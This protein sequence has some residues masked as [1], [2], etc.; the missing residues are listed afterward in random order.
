MGMRLHLHTLYI[1]RTLTTGSH[2]HPEEAMANLPD[3]YAQS[4]DDLM[5]VSIFEK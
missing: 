1:H 3:Q 5:F 4:M 2:E